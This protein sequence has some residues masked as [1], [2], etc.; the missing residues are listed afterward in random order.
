MKRRRVFKGVL[1]MAYGK[2]VIATVQ[3][4]T[5]PV[6]ASSWG[7][8][9]YGQWLLLATVPVFLA[10]GDLGFG[11]AAGHRLI[12]EV[13]KGDDDAARVTFQSAQ[14]VVLALSVTIL[15]LV[16]AISMV[17]P[18]HLLAVS[19]GLDAGE[20]RGVLIVLSAY[21]IVAMN[22]NLFLAA[23]RAQGAFALSASFDATIQLV[24]GLAVLVVVLSGGTQ[25]EAALTYLLIR[26]LGVAG[27]ATL[28]RR[29]AG[30]L[31]L[32]FADAKRARIHE[33]LRPALAAMLMPLAQAVNLQGTA[34]AV[35]A[36]AGAA[37][38]PIFT[39]LRTLSRVALQLLFT[40][41]L[42]VLP[43]LTAEHARGNVSWVRSVIGALTTLNALV[44]AIAGLCL[45]FGGSWLLAVWTKG[46]I[47]APEPM[48][49]LTAVGLVAGAV[50]NPMSQ[51]LLALNQHE[52]FAYAYAATAPAAVFLSF[53]LVSRWGVTGSAVASLL[54][55]LAMLGLVFVQLR[56]VAGPFPLG[57]RALQ[58]FI[59]ERRRPV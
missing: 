46:V 7:L 22:S 27:H 32:G 17:L 45:A 57:R 39:S 10:A 58:V 4:A 43:E 47:S 35:G 50:W 9:L 53:A 3:L 20:A 42:P 21:G 6:L 33:L 23:M 1:S 18:D 48:I 40:V 41:T 52:R 12:G 44:G 11:S 29:R 38:V 55:D 16:A 37:V 31:V 34:L 51:V 54:L 26:S 19:R 24:E 15:G 28:T 13:A 2:V 25:M 36:A 8:P 30:W 49:V 56:I 14:A 5:V 59:P